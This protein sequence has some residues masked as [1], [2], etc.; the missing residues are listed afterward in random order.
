MNHRIIN[1]RNAKKSRTWA[2]YLPIFIILLSLTV[3]TGSTFAFFADRNIDNADITFGKVE[4]S[5]GT[6]VGQTKVITDAL[7]GTPIMDEVLAFAKATESQPI[8]VRAKLSFS[9]VDEGN[10]TINAFLDELRNATADAMGIGGQVAGTNAYWSEKDGNYVYL[11]DETGTDLFSVTD[12][13]LYTL[14]STNITIPTSLTQGDDY[15]QYMQQIRFNFAFQAIQST[16]IVGTLTEKKAIFDEIFP[17]AVSEQLSGLGEIQ[18]FGM[19][20]TN[21][22]Q[23][24][25]QTMENTTQLPLIYNGTNNG[26][27]SGYEAY[28]ENESNIQNEITALPYNVGT[29]NNN[30]GTSN[31]NTTSYTGNTGE[32][33]LTYNSTLENNQTNQQLNNRMTQQ[34]ITY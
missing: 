27:T 19:G 2:K 31:S 14:T 29:A 32:N 28:N 23:I 33:A 20:T 18:S 5:D 21:S 15:S 9:L 7:P 10:E 25:S 22:N 1:N 3:I 17:E 26:A 11:T 4:L 24:N 8:Y 13:T 16:N 34:Q 12:S 30:Q 6:N